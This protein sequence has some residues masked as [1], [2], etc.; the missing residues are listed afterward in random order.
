MFE[1]EC[2]LS[3][4]L[5]VCLSAK[6]NMGLS[7]NNL[8]VHNIWSRCVQSV[9]LEVCCSL[10]Y[11]HA[12]ARCGGWCDYSA[13]VLLI[14]SHVSVPSALTPLFVWLSRWRVCTSTDW[15]GRNEW[16]KQKERKEE[17]QTKTTTA[18]LKKEE[19]EREKKRRSS[20][21]EGSAHATDWVW[22][23]SNCRF[24]WQWNPLSAVRDWAGLA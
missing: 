9:A 10:C 14:A 2:C 20:D 18:K 7:V 21:D 12:M 23:D 13:S 8:Y 22:L 17:K 3:A 24:N 1:S 16:L 15:L 5:S 6:A 11:L 19:R 4:C